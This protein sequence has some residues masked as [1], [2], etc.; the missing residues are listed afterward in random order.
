MQKLKRFP[1]FWFAVSQFLILLFQLDLIPHLDHVPTSL[2][3]TA[4]QLTQ[5]EKL[6]S[7]YCFHVI[8]LYTPLSEY[9]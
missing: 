7:S 5:V 1:V 2:I 9:S 6:Y 3:T 4:Q 8:L